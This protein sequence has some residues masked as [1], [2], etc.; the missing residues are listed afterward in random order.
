MKF[1]LIPEFIGRLPVVGAVS[2]LFKDAL[3]R[4]LVEPKNALVR[5]YQRVFELDG[6]ELEFTDDALEAVAE[7]ALL[8]GTGAR[9]LRAILEEV[10]LDVMYDLPEP[11]RR[12]QVRRR[13]GGRA[14]PG[15]P[16]PGARGRA[17]GQV[18]PQPPGRL[19]SPAVATS[20]F[21]SLGDAL[22]WLDGHIDFESAEPDARGPSRPSSACASCCAV[23]GD[24]AAGLPVVHVTG[25]NGKGSTAAMATALL[26]ADGP[27]RRHLHEPEPARG[28][29]AHRP[30]RA[31]P[32][33]TTRFAEVLGRPVPPRAAA[34]RAPHPLRAADGGRPAAGSPTRRSTR[35]WSR[36]GSGAPGTATN[37]VDAEV[38]VVT[39]V[40]YDHTE[41]LGPDPRGD[42][43]RQGGHRQGGPAGW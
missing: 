36:S 33:T 8:R 13:P 27:A 5:Q 23:L 31:S 14:R 17:P 20:P 7:Q 16:D 34:R 9:G 35:R 41:V 43:P 39:N 29:R 15:R 19:L 25:T 2:Q 42:R 40:S 12:R 38:A 11:H 1:G 10:L 32:S 24:P 4:I 37:V 30:R 6:V 18:Q 3:V 22:A 21:A 28:Q 26:G